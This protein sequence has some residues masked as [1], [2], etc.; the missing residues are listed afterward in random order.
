[1]KASHKPLLSMVLFLVTVGVATAGLHGCGK[2]S[3]KPAAGGPAAGGAPKGK[4]PVPVLVAVAEQADVPVELRALGS[5]EPVQSSPVRSQVA[6]TIVEVGFREGDLVKAGQTLF[7][8]DPRPIEATIR[9]L[10][11]NLARDRAQMLSAESQT[12]NTEAQVR[13]AEAQ[14]KNA[15]IQVKRYEELVAKEMV[16]REQYDQRATA[17][18]AAR[19]ALD[20]ARAV[21]QA[22]RSAQDAT[23]ATLEATQA[24]LENA[25]LQLE[26]TVIKRP[27]FRPGG[28]PAGRPR[29][30]GQ[31]ER[32]HPG[33]HQ[34]DP[35]DPGALHGARAAPAGGA[36]LPRRRDARRARRARRGRRRAARGALVFL[37]NAVDATTGTI[38]LKAEF[39]NPDGAL[40]AR[41]V[42]R[43]RAGSHARC[44]GRGRPLAGGA[45]R[46]AGRLRVRRGRRRRRR[47]PADHP[48]PGRGGP[49]G[50]RE[51]PRR[52]GDGGHRRPAAP[53][54]GRDGGAQNRALGPGGRAPGAA[55]SPKR[56]PALPRQAPEKPGE[57]LRALHPPARS[58]PRW[59]WPAS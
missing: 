49:H 25:K 50:R 16:A 18:D 7:R 15:E 5:V 26:Y 56:L 37:D 44:E 53:D 34:P 30:P 42:R 12:L 14:L 21:A 35:A 11:A 19:A 54:A 52:R 6:G 24:S 38:A 23:R 4:P 32:H 1:M 36:A 48:R 33:R 59:S 51:G 39:D 57:P 41:A 9:Q 31:G 55:A 43:R 17:L 22:S 20:A 3:E 10:Q 8:I 27:V 46:P 2:P 58:R 45:D 47:G 40:L 29:R 13:N 28:I